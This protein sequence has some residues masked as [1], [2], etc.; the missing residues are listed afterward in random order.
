MSDQTT[1]VVVEQQEVVFYGDE[2][3]AVRVED[4]TIYVPIRPICE[5]LGVDWSS[6]RQRINRDAVLSKY[7]VVVTTTKSGRGNPNMSALPLDYLNGWLFGI[8]ASRVS[9]EIRERLIQYQEE[10]YRV[11]AEV[12][13][14]NR[15]TAAPTI[16]GFDIDELLQTSD[17]PE[18]YAYRI[19]LA[20]ANM[21]RQQLA[22]RYR[23]DEQAGRLD[24]HEQ[25]IELIEAKL[26]DKSR[27]ITIAQAS[28]IS[29]SVKAIGL[30]LSSRSGRNEFGGVY[31]ELHRRFQITSYH[32]LPANK[33]DEAM[34]FLREWYQ[35]LNDTD[36]IPF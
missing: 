21:A 32:E 10:C 6:Q 13:Q 20:V 11:L 7:F 17:D 35:A 16:A 24:S 36:A 30:E 27:H 29:Q 12:F 33:Y 18:A 34:G 31:G 1:L 3:T 22:L 28:R 2:L 15:V 26:G 23:I 9:A 19:A 8:N 5:R 25:R 14:Q 4:G